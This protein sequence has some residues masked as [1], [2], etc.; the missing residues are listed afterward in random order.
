MLGALEKV[1]YNFKTLVLHNDNL[2]H[3]RKFENLRSQQQ[4]REQRLLSN[5]AGL[6]RLPVDSPNLK[7]R[8]LRT[9]L[10]TDSNK[11]TLWKGVVFSTFLNFFNRI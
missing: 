7:A 3:P 11:L 9:A 6:P 10:I 5:A 8:T 4:E 1:A 2:M